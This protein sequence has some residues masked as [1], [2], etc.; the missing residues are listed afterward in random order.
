MIITLFRLFLS[1]LAIVVLILGTN[2]QLIK[3]RGLPAF[4]RPAIFVQSDFPATN[5]TPQ[6]LKALLRTYS[7]QHQAALMQETITI[8]WSG[9]QGSLMARQF[10][11]GLL[12]L[13]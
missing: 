4:E 9:S 6:Q 3:P 11:E 10:S 8:E 7:A 1:V 13:G 5:E 12:R 2:S